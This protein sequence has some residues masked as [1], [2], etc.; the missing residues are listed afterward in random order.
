MDRLG[1]KYL[2]VTKHSS[3]LNRNISDKEKKCFLQN[4]DQ[5]KIAENVTWM[6]DG[7]QIT[8]QVRTL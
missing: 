3:L 7:K 1:C 6:K 5:D 8:E 4:F 2:P